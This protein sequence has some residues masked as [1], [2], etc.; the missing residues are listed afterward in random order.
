[1]RVNTPQFSAPEPGM[2]RWQDSKTLSGDVEA[3]G[4]GVPLDMALLR[5]QVR[6]KKT[7]GQTVGNHFYNRIVNGNSNHFG[8]VH[9]K[10]PHTIL[11]RFIQ[12]CIH[13]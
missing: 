9:T 6:R 1:M 3:H 2:G 4:Q 12:F 5:K 11:S 13:T 8:T 7:L 10:L